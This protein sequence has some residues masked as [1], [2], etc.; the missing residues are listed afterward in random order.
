[1]LVEALKCKGRTADICRVFPDP[2]ARLERLDQR[3]RATDLPLLKMRLGQERFDQLKKA[4]A[5]NFRAAVV[6]LV[7]GLR[8][9]GRDDDADALKAKALALDGSDEM[10]QA[11]SDKST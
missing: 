4:A 7:A 3:R 11:L 5:R 10:K 2:M 8:A 9:A 1:R 6:D